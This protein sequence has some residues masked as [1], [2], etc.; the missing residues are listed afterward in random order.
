MI[1]VYNKKQLTFTKPNLKQILK[2][3]L[4]FAVI[5]MIGGYVISSV[6][7][8]PNVIE[9][10]VYEDRFVLLSPPPK[11]TDSLL[12]DRILDLNIKY[13]HIVLAQALQESSNYT[14]DI[15][16]ENHNLFG[17]KNSTQRPTTAIGKHRG[18]AL[19][20]NWE[21]SVLD[22]AFY[23]TAYLRHIKSE[24]E[25]LSY[26]NKHYASDSIYDN[27]ISRFMAKTKKLVN[28]RIKAKNK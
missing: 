21:D 7:D 14:S 8:H 24:R 18:H 11:F 23:Q 22:Y 27:K 6:G 13:P 4:P 28:R 10:V 3:G 12:I 25:Y 16:F 20:K 15:F 19:Y 17:M 1:Y 26:L 5:F 9:K 2:W